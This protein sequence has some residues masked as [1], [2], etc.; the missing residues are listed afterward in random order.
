MA[1]CLLITE[2]ADHTSFFLFLNLSA[3]WWEDIP[4]EIS[5]MRFYPCSSS[6]HFL[7]YPSA[8]TSP[9]VMD[10]HPMAAEQCT[11][12]RTQTGPCIQSNA[13]WHSL[14]SPVRDCWMSIIHDSQMS[15]NLADHQN[16]KAVFFRSEQVVARRP[17]QIVHLVVMPNSPGNPS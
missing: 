11:P 1:T 14:C 16:G 9:E 5:Q 13:A 12:K 6:Y 7:S 17:G 10:L 2:V 8:S 4:E 3:W 15:G